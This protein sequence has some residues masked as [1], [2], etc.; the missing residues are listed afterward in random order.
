M[1]N[2]S[3]AVRLADRVYVYDNSVDDAGALLC[4]RT[5]DG[6][7]RKIYADLPRWVAEAVDPL[8]R[9]PQFVDMRAA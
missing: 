1:A 7:L 2:L 4:A 9:H 6:K 3:A 5:Q 8:E